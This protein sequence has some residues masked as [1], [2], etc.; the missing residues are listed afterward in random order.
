M[1]DFQPKIAARKAAYW[2]GLLFFNVLFGAF[3]RLGFFYFAFLFIS[4]LYF[5]FLF[6]FFFRL[7]SASGCFL[8]IGFSSL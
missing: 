2:S 7:T 4:I 1:C 5:F 8:F 6:S 3:F